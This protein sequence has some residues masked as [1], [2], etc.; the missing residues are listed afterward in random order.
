MRLNA[1]YGLTATALVEL[2]LAKKCSAR[3]VIESCLERI[4]A[5][6]PVVRAFVDVDDDSAL[7][8]ATE[9]DDNGVSG[10]LH[11][12]PI[13]VKETVDVAGLR[14]PLGT[15]IHKSRTP[16][17]DAI[18][19]QRLR[20]AG[21]IILG[22]TVSTEYAI[23]RAGPTTNPH[24]PAY[25]PGGSSSGSAAA[26]A[27][28]MVPIAV[29]TQTVGSIIRPSTYC[30]IF[31][32]KPTKDAIN[33][34]GSM[35][36][37]AFLDHIG[38]MART[39]DDVSLACDVMFDEGS[40]AWVRG[41]SAASL[42]RAI[43]IEGPM[44]ERIEPP[45][46]EALKRAQSLLEANDIPVEEV[47]LPKSFAHLVSCYETI[48]FRDIAV[49]HGP[50]RD[51]FGAFMSDR[52]RKIIDDGRGVSDRAYDEATSQAQR[53]RQEILNLLQEATIILAPATDGTAP[54]FSDQTGPQRLQALWTLVGFPALAV[55]C[56]KVGGLP[57]GV[58]L[59]GAPRHDHLVL[60]AGK[61]FEQEAPAEP[62]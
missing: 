45:T 29:G 51:E 4:A 16:A 57:V 46:R 54:P 25:T 8:R 31:G 27:A 5:L 2:L 14:C 26:V 18:V 37:S 19:V 39:V 55:P 52:L 60:E 43:R 30:G 33:P 28:A 61:L 36:L 24:N 40:V 50:D 48:L 59:I 9:L 53:Y 7:R 15:H 34:A 17:R 23:A 41:S 12:V 42:K 13:A 3:Q 21:A 20:D 6:D 22:T 35:P 10:P 1:L 11:G 56:G 32:L 38:P 58:Q 47:I 62:D 44:Q 49:N